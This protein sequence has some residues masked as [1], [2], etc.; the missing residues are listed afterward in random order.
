MRRNGELS[1][2]AIDVPQQCIDR[3]APSRCVRTRPSFRSKARTRVSFGLFSQVTHWA[4]DQ[5]YSRTFNNCVSSPQNPGG[6]YIIAF[7]HRRDGKRDQGCH[8]SEPVLEIPDAHQGFA[9]QRDRFVGAPTPYRYNSADIQGH[10]QEPRTDASKYG[11]GLI[12]QPL[13]MFGVA[14]RE[15]YRSHAAKRIPNTPRD[16]QR[17]EAFNTPGE[18]IAG[19]VDISIGV[20]DMPEHNLSVRD[21]FDIA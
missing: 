8:K 13:C 1:S 5:S 2:G 10:R 9:D 16:R 4:I 14:G 15:S 19:Q 6:P 21:H 7:Q 17:L 20:F 18:V 12:E 3:G 11:C